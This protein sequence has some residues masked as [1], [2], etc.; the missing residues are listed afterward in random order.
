MKLVRPGLYLLVIGCAL[1]LPTAVQAQWVAY[2]DFAWLPE[3]G[4]IFGGQGG[5]AEQ[6]PDYRIIDDDPNSGLERVTLFTHSNGI[7]YVDSTLHYK[8][9]PLVEPPLGDGSQAKSGFLRDYADGSTLPVAVDV[10]HTGT[11]F[12]WN[13]KQGAG[14][15]EAPGRDAYDEFWDPNTGEAII[16]LW[17]TADGHDYNGTQTVTLSNLDP[18]K[19]YEYVTFGNFGHWG[20][21]RNGVLWRWTEIQG[22]DTDG[23]QNLSSVDTDYATAINVN[24]PNGPQHSVGHEQRA[25]IRNATDPSHY[26][27]NSGEIWFDGWVTKF[28]FKPGADGEVSIV[29][30]GINNAASMEFVNIA[31]PTDTSGV[32][33]WRH[34]EVSGS[35]AS[36][37]HLTTRDAVNLRHGNITDPNDANFGANYLSGWKA[38]SNPA[39]WPADPNTLEATVGQSESLG[40]PVN[41]RWY[42]AGFKL[43]E[44]VATLDDADFNGDGFVDGID[45][46]TWQRNVGTGTMQS[47]GDANGDMMVDGADLA[48]WESQYGTS[49]LSAAAS[50]VP[51][52]STLLMV[53]S[54][55]LFYVAGRLCRRG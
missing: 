32:P 27:T 41:S 34:E 52:P 21:G 50:A 42:L 30:R 9:D 10:T 26:V 4:N 49:P 8:P 23:F 15:A 22:H 43:E 25:V 12:N 51:E 36:V 33:E 46:L 11:T 40:D 28:H 44:L 55:A 2:N 45:F 24:D 38:H 35:G 48:I 16:G 6:D 7:Q 54:S 5:V 14:A 19:F 31:D 18:S 37:V 53:L 20:T 29:T 47:Q 3:P 17:G 1:A 13:I 39:M